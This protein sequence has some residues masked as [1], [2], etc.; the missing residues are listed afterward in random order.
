MLESKEA[1]IKLLNDRLDLEKEKSAFLRDLADSR[2][3]ESDLLISAN[4][5]LKEAI[6]LKESVISNQSKEVEILKKKKTSVL[7][8]IK[9]VAVGVSIGMILK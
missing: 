1:E 3:N 7:T 5:A 6:A 8:I 4:N 2:K 9:A